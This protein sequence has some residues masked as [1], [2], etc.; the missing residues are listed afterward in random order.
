MLAQEEAQMLIDRDEV[1][2]EAI[3]RAEEDG[4]I[5]IDEMDKIAGREKASVPMSP[6]KVSNGTYCPSWKGRRC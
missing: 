4:I 5:F 2:R 6:A 1:V 3:R